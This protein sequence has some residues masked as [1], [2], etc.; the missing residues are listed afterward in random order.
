M[1]LASSVLSLANDQS[2]YGA[3]Y[4]IEIMVMISQA[5]TKIG[6]IFFYNYDQLKISFVIIE[7]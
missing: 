2:S 7:D 6:T 4:L 5:Q 1:S 3:K